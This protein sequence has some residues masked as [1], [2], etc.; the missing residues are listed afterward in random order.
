MQMIKL[1][2]AELNNKYNIS[3]NTWDRRHDDLL[4]YLQD[5]MNIIEVK[6]RGR[7]YY[8]IEGEL[9][10]SIPTIPRKSRK[11]VKIQKYEDYTKDQLTD[12]YQP[13]SK[14]RVA[15]L[16]IKNFGTKEFNH[17]S[18]EAVARRYVGPAMDKYGEHTERYYWVN[19]DN[20][21][22]MTDEQIAY[23]RQCFTENDLDEEQMETIAV[24][25]LNNKMPSQQKQLDYR[26]AIDQFRSEYGFIPVKVPKWRLKQQYRQSAFDDA[27]T[28][29]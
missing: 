14:S 13:N 21:K 5:F 16:A 27:A 28:E 8:E 1:T 24:D 17:H 7:Y 3:H 23:L 26:D 19:Y 20:Y 11:A 10:E 6:E 18:T 12:D 2:R 22:L 4:D 9:P 29:V 25:A 15:R